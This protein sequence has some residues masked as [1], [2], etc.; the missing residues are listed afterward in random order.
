MSLSLHLKTIA[1]IATV[2]GIIAI[3]HYTPVVVFQ[4]LFQACFFALVLGAA[5]AIYMFI[6][7]TYKDFSEI[8]RAPVI[9]APRVRVP[10]PVVD[11]RLQPIGND[12]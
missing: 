5:V 12:R 8:P 1:T 7:S 2:A 10:D 6:Y 3:I 9:E 4:Y 11:A